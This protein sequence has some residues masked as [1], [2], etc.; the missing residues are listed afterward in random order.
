ME[1]RDE[2]LKTLNKQG[3][4]GTATGKKERMK[5]GENSNDECV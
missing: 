4:K 5:E 2:G 3:G 1:R